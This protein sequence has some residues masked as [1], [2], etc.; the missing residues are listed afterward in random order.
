MLRIT[1]NLGTGT[2]FSGN[3]VNQALTASYS[4]LLSI[5]EK[6]IVALRRFAAG[7]N[8]GSSGSK[9]SCMKLSS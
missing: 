2:H 1:G 7:T 9:Y 4:I 6:V 5:P 8:G 3:R